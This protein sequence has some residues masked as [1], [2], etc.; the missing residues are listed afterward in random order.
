M[1][2]LA[3]GL[4]LGLKNP[5]ASINLANRLRTN[6]K[7]SIKEWQ[8]YNSHIFETIKRQRSHIA[9][10]VALIAFVGSF[11]IFTTLFVSVTQRQKDISILKSLGAS[12]R[13]IL[14]IFIKQGALLGFVGGILG[15]LLALVGAS[16][17]SIFLINIPKIYFLPS[18]PV[19]F[20]FIVYLQVF[21]AG[22]F[23]STLAGLYPA[24]TATFI[25]PTEG[26][27]VGRRN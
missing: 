23:V 15:V 6:Y 2:N 22:F 16:L 26:I 12:N 7:M 24:F 18:L 19:N 8:S 14:M 3:T 13:S 5:N 25:S 21:F 17:L 27:N 9:F 11:N 1:K 4:E 20:D 10:L